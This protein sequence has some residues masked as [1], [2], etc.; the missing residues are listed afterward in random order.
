[1]VGEQRLPRVP[2]KPVSLVVSQDLKA[3]FEGYLCVRAAHIF[4]KQHLFL[5]QMGKYLAVE[6]VVSMHQCFVGRK[7]WLPKRVCHP[8]P[9]N[10][11]GKSPRES[12]LSLH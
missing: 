5:I 3:Q 11:K 2:R 10:T 1:M 8:E 9:R 6:V 7:H 4:D 12:E